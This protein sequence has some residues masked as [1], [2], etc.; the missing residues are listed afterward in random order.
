MV[1]NTPKVPLALLNLFDLNY[2]INILVFVY[3]VS[4]PNSPDNIS[5]NF[6]HK[7]R[8]IRTSV[9]LTIFKVF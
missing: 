7:A 1:R 3:I 6:G 4:Y 9:L 8:S 5:G 2:S